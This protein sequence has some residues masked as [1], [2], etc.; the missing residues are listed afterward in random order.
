MAGVDADMTKLH[1]FF[2]N[3]KAPNGYIWIF[4]KGN[5]T[6]NVG[7]GI[8]GA[9]SEEGKRAMDLLDRFIAENPRFFK[10]ASPIEVNGGGI[11]VNISVSTFVAD[12]FMVIGDAAQ[13]VNPIHGGGMYLAMNAASMAAKVAAAA[14]SEGNTTRERLLE[15]ERTWHEVDGSRMKKILK[16]RT[17][18]EKLNDNDLED[19]SG[20]LSGEEILRLTAGDN[21]V[22]VK[23]LTT[24]APK[25]LPLVKKFLL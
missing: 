15:Y 2:G 25:L 17:F 23:V 3:T 22:L 5:T 6:A 11:P 19:L 12:G 13:Q 1:L 7:I 18:V 24:K 10:N 4:P 14:I 8:V 16:I 20:I 9:R 21:S